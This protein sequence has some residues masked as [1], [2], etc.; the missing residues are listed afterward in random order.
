MS[1]FPHLKPWPIR[2]GRARWW[3]LG[4]VALLASG[5][6]WALTLTRARMEQ[7]APQIPKVN[8]QPAPR[9]VNSQPAP[10][11]GQPATPPD[12]P[13]GIGGRPMT[14]QEASRLADFTVIAPATDI[15]NADRLTGVWAARYGAGDAQVA[16]QYDGGA[17]SI[18]ENTLADPDGHPGTVQRGCRRDEPGGWANRVLRDDRWQY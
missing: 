3:A 1:A 7:P 15:A 12:D 13:F 8:S 14:L 5:T 18:L 6:V 2:S 9:K 17:L 10:R 11:S 16:L 4:L